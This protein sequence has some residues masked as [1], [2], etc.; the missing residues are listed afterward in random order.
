MPTFA[1]SALK[2]VFLS[3]RLN[4]PTV[5]SGKTGAG[6]PFFT[7]FLRYFFSACG[8]FIS[9]F[10]CCTSVD[11]PLPVCPIIPKNSPSSICRFIPFNALVAN[12]DFFEYVKVRFFTSISHSWEEFISAGL[13]GEDFAFEMPRAERFFIMPS[14]SS[15]GRRTLSNFMPAPL[16]VFIISVM[17]GRQRLYI[18]SLSP[19]SKISSGVP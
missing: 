17:R 14:A 6:R 12:G 7:F 11:L 16:R 10:K 4:C 5:I 8:S 18:S 13:A 9:A 15:S 2:S 1:R 19:L 3:A